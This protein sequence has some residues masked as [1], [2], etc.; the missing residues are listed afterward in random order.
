MLIPGNEPKEIID[1][2]T[3]R[4]VFARINIVAP[5]EIDKIIPADAGIAKDRKAKMVEKIIMIGNRAYFHSGHFWHADDE[6]APQVERD[7]SLMTVTSMTVRDRRR[8]L[9]A[10]PVSEEDHRLAFDSADM[11]AKATGLPEK[12]KYDF[13]ATARGGETPDFAQVP[14]KKLRGYFG[15]LQEKLEQIDSFIDSAVVTHSTLMTAFDYYEI[16]MKHYVKGHLFEKPVLSERDPM[17]Q[18]MPPH[19]RVRTLN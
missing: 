13:G 2:A 7:V 15:T 11:M 19:A 14:F 16:A 8:A 18:V 5:V 1:R 9:V 3:Y 6:C 4:E 10:S 12:L 17:G